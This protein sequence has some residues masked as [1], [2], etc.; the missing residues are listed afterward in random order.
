MAEVGQRGGVPLALQ[1]RFDDLQ[2]G[3]PEHVADHFRQ[4]DVHLLQGLLDVLYLAAGVLDQPLTLPQV[5]PQHH[6]VVTRP[7]RPGQKTAAVQSPDPLAVEPVALG[8]A[9]HLPRLPRVDEQDGEAP[10]LEQFEQGDPIDAGRLHGHGGHPARLQP[11]GDG[12]QVVGAG[13][14][15]ANVGGQFIGTARGWRDRPGRDGDPVPVGMNVDAGGL[16]VE[17]GKYLHARLA[18]HDNNLRIPVNGASTKGCRRGRA[19]RCQ[20][21]EREHAGRVTSGWNATSRDQ[22]R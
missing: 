13:A 22:A 4:L 6:D 3:Q 2:P 21:L 16:G 1:D 14:E 20:S 8:P 18:G 11:V 5:T 17:D 7:E 12:L 19:C 9:A 15:L 10:P